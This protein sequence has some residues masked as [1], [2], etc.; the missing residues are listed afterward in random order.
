M[1][2]TKELQKLVDCGLEINKQYSS[3]VGCQNKT[4]GDEIPWTILQYASAHG[5]QEVIDFLVLNGAH[6]GSTDKTN[7]TAQDISDFLGRNVD[8]KKVIKERSREKFC[9]SNHL[10]DIKFN[11]EL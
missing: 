8:I 4:Y 11:F 3:P 2:N 7:R 1:N 9:S 10:F 6:Y 5:F